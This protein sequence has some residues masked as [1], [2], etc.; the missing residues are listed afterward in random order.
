MEISRIKGSHPILRT[1]EDLK[2]SFESPLLGAEIEIE[3]RL[4]VKV[5]PSNL[6][7]V[8]KIDLYL[9]DTFVSSVNAAPFSWNAE[10]QENPL[11]NIEIG[12]YSLKAIAFNADG[13]TS[14]ITT[15]L[16]VF[17]PE[18]DTRHRI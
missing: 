7:E 14:E 3:E 2:I 13:A 11:E 1:T 5:A 18:C 17:R 8:S 15:Q 9:N 6:D 12:N 4:I 16:T 10:G